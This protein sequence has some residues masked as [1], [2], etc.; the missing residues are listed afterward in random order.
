[1]ALSVYLVSE[2]EDLIN[3][4]GISKGITN[5]DY[6]KAQQRTEKQ[7]NFRALN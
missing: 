2:I 4:S 3:Y 7:L 1:M 6:F 5:I